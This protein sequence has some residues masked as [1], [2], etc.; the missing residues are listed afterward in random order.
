MS[1]QVYHRDHNHDRTA[2]DWHREFASSLLIVNGIGWFP[3]LKRM[4]SSQP[5]A[6]EMLLDLLLKYIL[7]TGTGKFVFLS[8][9]EVY[10]SMRSTVSFLIGIFSWGATRVSVLFSPWMSINSCVLRWTG[11]VL[12]SSPIFSFKYDFWWRIAVEEWIFV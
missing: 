12:P 5:S 1:Y 4:E 11:E 7:F 8:N 10:T 6:V 3:I 2:L 9:G